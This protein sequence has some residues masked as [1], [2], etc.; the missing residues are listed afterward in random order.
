MAKELWVD[1]GLIGREVAPSWKDLI[2][3]M[4]ADSYQSEGPFFRIEGGLSNVIEAKRM[5]RRGMP[6]V[7]V[8]AVL[9][10]N[11]FSLH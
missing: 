4:S 3:R 8:D 5:Q 11:V 9:G 2:H 10:S 7:P 6:I 1:L